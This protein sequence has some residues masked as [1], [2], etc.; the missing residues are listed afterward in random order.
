MI[1]MATLGLYIYRIIVLI[2][3]FDIYDAV[4]GKK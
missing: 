4:K 3:L 1:S 2:T